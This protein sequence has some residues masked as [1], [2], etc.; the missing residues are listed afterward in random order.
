MDCSRD[1]GQP[2]EGWAAEHTV[3]QPTPCSALYDSQL[4][5]PTA[6]G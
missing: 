3:A 5:A 4:N 2:L 6:P 1:P